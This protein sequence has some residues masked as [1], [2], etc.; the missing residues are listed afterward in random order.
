MA[1][2]LPVGPC[3]FPRQPHHVDVMQ[4]CQPSFGSITR[5]PY[6]LLAPAVLH[7][8]FA[9]L[10]ATSQRGW[11]P[12]RSTYGTALKLLTLSIPV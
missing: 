1:P 6:L 7:L 8:S 5:P 4:G 2:P 3:H 9:C 11:Q 10:P 12:C